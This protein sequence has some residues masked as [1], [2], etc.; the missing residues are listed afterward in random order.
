MQMSKQER[1][2]KKRTTI[3]RRLL[4]MMM[5]M[6]VL[7]IAGSAIAIIIGNGVEV[8]N[9][10]EQ[11][12]F[13]YTRAAVDLIDGD[14]V[15]KYLETGE[16]D[17]YYLEIERY[18]YSMQKET[19]IV[20]YY[21]FVPHE[22]DK[23][24]VWDSN[25]SKERGEYPLGYL[26]DYMPGED[27]AAQQAFRHDPTERIMGSINED[28]G[29]FWV[30]CSPVFDS[31]GNPVAVAAV[32]LSYDS[33][34]QLSLYYI[35]NVAIAIAI[36]VA[37]FFTIQY[38]NVKLGIINPIKSLT[39][40]TSELVERI[41]KGERFSIDIHTNDEIE[42][43]VDAF[44]DMDDGLRRYI[45]ENARIMS[46]KERIST[47]L[48]MAARI[49]SSSLPSVF[50]PFPD[51]KEIDIYATMEPAKEIGGDFYDFFF[52]DEDHLALV[53]ADVSG[54][55]IPAA[56]FMMVSK[57]VIQTGAQSNSSP[58][59][60]LIETNRVLSRDNKADMFV[61]VWMGVL[62]LS[63]GRLKYADAGHE[64]LAVLHDGEWR[65]MEKTYSG[66]AICM[67]EPDEMDKMPEKYHIVDQEIVLKP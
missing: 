45:R 41:E 60:V 16:V 59:E 15:K 26:D 61:T 2:R 57:M 48:D 44:C 56:L 25:W 50:P 32:N 43:L 11:T 19:D 30:A 42:Q 14:K 66:I 62:E 8:D 55:G 23:L 5:V 21:V 53:V 28:V 54:K 7:L 35:R 31:E 17:D 65:L 51:R 10:Y 20:R 52:V 39:E 12:A 36:M 13:G 4:C 9:V 49:Q 1:R 58:K 47:E 46:E 18:L 64:R 33:T 24:F 67:V 37:F 38:L 40:A 27:I 29:N 34:N 63:T 22:E 3:S 6:G